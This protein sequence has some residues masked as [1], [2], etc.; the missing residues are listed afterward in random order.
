MSSLSRDILRSFMHLHL[1][2]RAAEGPIPVQE[3]T[4]ELVRHGYDIAPQTLDSI[5]R[6]LETAGYLECEPASIGAGGQL[7]YRT[8]PAGR[9]A[10][11]HLRPGIRALGDR[12]LGNSSDS[13]SGERAA[14][15]PL[16]RRS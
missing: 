3:L 14:I 7:C 16:E 15:P 8:T 13:P 10:L 11:T 4:D 9:E 12:V 2:H 6:R 5:L 1:L